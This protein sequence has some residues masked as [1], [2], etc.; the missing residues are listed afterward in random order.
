LYQRKTLLMLRAFFSTRY[1]QQLLREGKLTKERIY[2]YP[3][4]LYLFV[5]PCFLLVLF[6]FIDFKP[7]TNFKPHVLYGILGGGTV[8][9]LSLSHLCLSCFTTIF[10][11]SEQKYLF[12]SIKTL[13]RFI[14]AILLLCFIPVA[15]YAVIPNLLY[16]VY[17]PLYAIITFVFI[18]LFLKN[19]SK[20][21]GINF[22]I[23]FCSLEI[24]PCLLLIKLLSIYL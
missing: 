6:N 13:F 12:L 15:W 19:V 20:E 11:Y 24:L 4:L 7:F 1:L 23:Y 8:V 22:F 14:N 10:N 17:L 5:I 16:Y 21:S 9:A 18:F 3:V 2:F